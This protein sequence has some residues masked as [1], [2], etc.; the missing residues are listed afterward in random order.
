MTVKRWYDPRNGANLVEGINEI[1]KGSV[2]LSE[3]DYRKCTVR[4]LDADGTP[5]SDGAA[6]PGL[7]REQVNNARLRAYADPLTGSDRLFNESN[8]MRAM[9]EEGWEAVLAQGAE[10]YKQ[11][12]EQYPWG[13]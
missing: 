13:K 10:R 8:R 1:P 2:R 12:Q 6:A 9:G 4:I 5:V 11:I 3:E 7:D